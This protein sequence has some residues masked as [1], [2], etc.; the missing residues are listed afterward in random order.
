[1]LG[2]KLKIGTRL[3]YGYHPDAS[4]S[5]TDSVSQIAVDVTGP[6]SG[7]Y[8]GVG[9]DYLLWTKSDTSVGS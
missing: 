2:E 9:V 8:L 5:L 1:M 6:V 7:I 3:G 4:V